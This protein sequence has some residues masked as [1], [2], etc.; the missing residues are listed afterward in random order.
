[1][2]QSL[3]LQYI[4]K[5]G[6]ISSSSASLAGRVRAVAVAAAVH[7]QALVSVVL[8]VQGASSVSRGGRISLGRAVGRALAGSRRAVAMLAG[9]LA[10]ADVVAGLA[11]SDGSSVTLGWCFVSKSL[12]I[13]Q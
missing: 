1:M 8:A 4:W 2:K 5:T 10:E 9:E 12:L 7:A 3:Y 13:S 6:E 11:I